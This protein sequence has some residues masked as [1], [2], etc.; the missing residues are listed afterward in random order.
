MFE[1]NFLALEIDPADIFSDPVHNV[2]TLP[3][4]EHGVCTKGKGVNVYNG[5]DEWRTI[6][7]AA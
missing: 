1:F 2:Y 7:E 4:G 5:L 6:Q 3:V